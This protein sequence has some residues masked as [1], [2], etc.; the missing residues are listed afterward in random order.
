MQ[1]A[2]ITLHSSGYSYYTGSEG[3][4]GITTDKKTDTL[5]VSMEGFQKHSL[6]V[7]VSEFIEIKLK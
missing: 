2:K 7:D 6:V 1:N 3:T 5:T 4:F